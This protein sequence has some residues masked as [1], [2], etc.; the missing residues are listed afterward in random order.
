MLVKLTPGSTILLKFQ[1]LN[2]Y[3]MGNKAGH[4]DK[5]KSVFSWYKGFTTL[6]GLTQVR[7]SDNRTSRNQMLYN[8]FGPNLRMILI[9]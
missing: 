6:G 2:W 1:N 9:S 4:R 8:F 3:K 5:V 7:D